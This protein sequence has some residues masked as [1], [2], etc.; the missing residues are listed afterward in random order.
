M[1]WQLQKGGH[2]YYKGMWII[3]D[4]IAQSKSHNATIKDEFALTKVICAVQLNPS[5]VICRFTKHL[6][7][8][9]KN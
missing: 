4:I 7:M 8:N 2:Y 3:S 9:Y 5:L 1:L 6:N